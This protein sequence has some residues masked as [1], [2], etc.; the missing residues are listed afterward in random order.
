MQEPERW[1]TKGNQILSLPHLLRSLQW[2][3]TLWLISKILAMPESLSWSGFSPSD[4]P[5][6]PPHTHHHSCIF[7]HFSFL[8]MC[9]DFSCQRTSSYGS[10]LYFLLAFAKI[11][12]SVHP[13]WN[14][15]SLNTS[16]PR[17][18]HFLCLI[19]FHCTYH[20]LKLNYLFDCLLPCFMK[21]WHKTAH[22]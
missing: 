3:I 9:H 12:Y 1:F 11:L 8:Q 2:P 19:S 10:P 16:P 14:S 4:L 6:I 20:Y 7:W 17:S 21:P 22:L 15:I 13:K 5:L 18:I